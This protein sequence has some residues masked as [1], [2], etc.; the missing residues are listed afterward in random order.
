MLPYNPSWLSNLL[1]DGRRSPDNAP[2]KGDN[3]DNSNVAALSSTEPWSSG[4]ARTSRGSGAN[5]QRI[6]TVH[7][8][9]SEFVQCPQTS[10]EMNL[11]AVDRLLDVKRLE[12]EQT[13]AQALLSSCIWH[14]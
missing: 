11:H 9:V 4:M 7:S 2:P 5:L 8:G 13:H 6:E 3:V 12:K 10:H 14:S 1:T